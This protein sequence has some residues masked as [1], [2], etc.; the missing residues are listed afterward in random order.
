MAPLETRE[1]VFVVGR[2]CITW[3]RVLLQTADWACLDSYGGTHFILKKREKKD[4]SGPWNFWEKFMLGFRI[5]NHL[6]FTISY[7]KF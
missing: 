1:L 7:G 3:S 2:V 6:S 5:K 4:D